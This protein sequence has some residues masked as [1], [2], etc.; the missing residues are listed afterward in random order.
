L[1]GY[2]AVGGDQMFFGMHGFDFTEI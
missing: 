2:I 1:V